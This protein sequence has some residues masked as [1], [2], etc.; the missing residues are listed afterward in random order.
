MTSS[1]QRFSV[2]APDIAAAVQLASSLSQ[3][4]GDVAIEQETGPRYRVFGTAG[5]GPCLVHSL[6]TE[7]IERDQICCAE[8]VLAGERYQLTLA[9]TAG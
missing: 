9:A 5:I 7:W 4:G 2:Q 8:L 6:V 1:G 3:A